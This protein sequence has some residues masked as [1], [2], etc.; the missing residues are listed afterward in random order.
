MGVEIKPKDL[1][2]YPEEGSIVIVDDKVIVKFS[3]I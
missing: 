2:N 3:D 1:P